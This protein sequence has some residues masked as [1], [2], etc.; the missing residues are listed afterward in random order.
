MNAHWKLVK[1]NAKS[2]LRIIAKYY[3]CNHTFALYQILKQHPDFPSFL[4]L[5]YILQR[6]GKES[7][8]LH[9]SYNDLHNL[10]LP[11]II[12]SSMAENM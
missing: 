12:I 11:A 9:I 1:N 5:Q 7:F 3:K 4:S 8:T 2:I 6:I 10:P